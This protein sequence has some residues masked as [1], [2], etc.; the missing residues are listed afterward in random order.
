VFDVLDEIIDDSDRISDC[1][2]D[3]AGD[4]LNDTCTLSAQQ[5]CQSTSLKL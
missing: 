3:Q 5:T 4:Q 1:S 2:V